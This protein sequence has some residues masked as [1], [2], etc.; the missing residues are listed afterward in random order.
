MK[1]TFVLL[2]PVNVGV[3]RQKD[4]AIL[5]VTRNFYL[6]THDLLDLL[7]DLSCGVSWEN[8]PLEHG[9]DEL[10]HSLLFPNLSWSW[11]WLRFANETRW[12]YTLLT[13]ITPKFTWSSQE[14]D[15]QGLSVQSNCSVRPPSSSPW[16][17]RIWFCTVVK[18]FWTWANIHFPKNTLEWMSILN[19]VHCRPHARIHE[20]FPHCLTVWELTGNK[21]VVQHDKF[22]TH[23]RKSLNFQHTICFAARTMVHR[24]NFPIFAGHRVEL[25]QTVLFCVITLC[26]WDRHVVA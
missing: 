25:P 11:M 9:W 2:I 14:Y 21:L 8:P 16:R 18:S 1:F 22:F 20:D 7:E 19:D 26:F 4:V 24:Q 15:F 10:C 6:I 17:I 12:R 23:T 5:E 13:V 3:H